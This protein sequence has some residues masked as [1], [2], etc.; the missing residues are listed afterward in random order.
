MGG[1]RKKSGG[2]PAPRFEG[3]SPSSPRAS[4]TARAIGRE[5]TRAEVSLRRALWAR[6]IRYRKNVGTVPG[7]PDVVIWWARVAV[8][9]DGDFW[10]GR[11]WNER[12]TKL[13]RGANASYWVA[14]ISANIERDRRQ[15]AELG[16]AGWRVLRVWETDV[17]KDPDVHANRIAIMASVP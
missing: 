15:T 5:E 7:R 4:A 6:G 14:K 2:A 3:F 11:D 16:A 1:V 8:F 13:Q 9:V 17:L 12:L 10:H